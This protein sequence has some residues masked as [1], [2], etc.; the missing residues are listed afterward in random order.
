M[1]RSAFKPLAVIA[2]CA[3]D[4]GGTYAGLYAFAFARLLLLGP[5]SE[6]DSPE[7]KGIVLGIGTLATVLGGFTAG[8]FAPSAALVHGIAVGV[9]AEVLGL[10]S[11]LSSEARAFDVWNGIGLAVSLPAAMA[12]A[13]L[14]RGDD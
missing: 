10:L 1:A 5:T 9:V 2:G 7:M 6:P 4:Y 14:S 3:V 13:L 11:I 12:G 8:R